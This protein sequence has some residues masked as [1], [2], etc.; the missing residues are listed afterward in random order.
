MKRLSKY[1]NHSHIG[2]NGE[3]YRSKREAARHQELQLLMFA[4]EISELRREVP[5]VLA[6]GVR[7]G[8]ERARPPIRYVADFTYLDKAGRPVVEDSKGYK[9]DVYKIKRHLMATVHGIEVL[10][11]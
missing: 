4:G 6:P 5:F 1:G 3:K 7:I 9:N 11:S 10:E 2:A 8:N